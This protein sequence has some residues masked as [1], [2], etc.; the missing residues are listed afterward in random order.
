MYSLTQLGHSLASR[1]V[2]YRI[3]VRGDV[4]TLESMYAETPSDNIKFRLKKAANG[5][6]E[7]RETC[8]PCGFNA[9]LCSFMP[10][11]WF[12]LIDSPM[13]CRG[14]G[15]KVEFELLDTPFMSKPAAQNALLVLQLNNSWPMFLAGITQALMEDVTV[16]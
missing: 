3:S 9:P 12:P 6:V 11:V 10:C 2:G 7:H 1:F 13:C 5:F 16:M 15:G 4:A 8:G 14:S